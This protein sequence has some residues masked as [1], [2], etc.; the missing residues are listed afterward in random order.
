MQVKEYEPYHFSIKFC[1]INFIVKFYYMCY[2]FNIKYMKEI[3][4]MGYLDKYWNEVHKKYTSTYDGWLDK[5]L[6]LFNKND[7]I[8]DLGCGRAY[9]SQYLLDNGFTDIAACDFSEEVLKILN[10][11]RP[12]LKT[13]LFDMSNGLPFEDNSENIVIA[14]LSL[15]YFNLSKTKLIFE[16]IYRILKK[17]GYLIARVNST[18]DKEHI[19]SNCEEIEENFYYDGN[20]YK[21]FFTKEDF[22]FLFTNFQIINLEEKNMSRYEKTKVLWE[23]CI[24]K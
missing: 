19:P 24:K 4:I 6:H 12:D 18:D 13:M 3:K 23:F 20:I 14:D 5:Y 22:D 7:S 8:I 9:C 21:K 15:H 16:D 2:Y 10:D 17:D 1:V 11:E